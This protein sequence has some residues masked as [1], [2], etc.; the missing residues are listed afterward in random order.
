M[1]VGTMSS[2]ERLRN[3]MVDQFVA[4]QAAEG[5]S[6]QPDVEAALRT[7]PRELFTPGVSLERAYVNDVVSFKRRGTEVIST[8]SAPFVIA[9]MLGQAADAL[10]G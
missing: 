9:R 4:D 2:S 1:S 6:P 3:E 7:V 8:V 5:S 10:C